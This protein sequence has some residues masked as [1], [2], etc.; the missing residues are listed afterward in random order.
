MNTLLI[1]AAAIG[2]IGVISVVGYA[3]TRYESRLAEKHVTRLIDDAEGDENHAVELDPPEVR[4]GILQLLKIWRHQSKAKKLA[5]KGYIKWYKL[6][7]TIQRPRWVKPR[8]GGTGEAEYY[9][10]DDDVTYLFP[11]DGMLPDAQT[12]AWTAMHR[13]NEADPINLRDGLMPAV[14]SDRLQ[15]IINLEAESEEPGFFD[16]HDISGTQLFIVVTV[17]L[18]LVYAATQVLGGGL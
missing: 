4:S 2:V 18:F 5:E 1:A 10:S 16:K 17:I 9:D 6:D 14:P 13:R 11:K 3:W 8:Y 12:G 15:E 7:A